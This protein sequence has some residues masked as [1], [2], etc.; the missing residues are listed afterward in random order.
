M[1]ASHDSKTVFDI[2]SPNLTMAF[3]QAGL[4][5]GRFGYDVTSYF[6]FNSTRNGIISFSPPKRHKNTGL[7][8]Q[9]AS[10]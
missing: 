3:T 8:R 7:D 4:L 5:Y 6:T 10:T 2:K 1:T 9:R